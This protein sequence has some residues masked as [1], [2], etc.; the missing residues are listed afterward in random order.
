[1]KKDSNHL[2][3]YLKCFSLLRVERD[4]IEPRS[5]VLAIMLKISLVGARAEGNRFI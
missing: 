4:T 3:Y 1:M 5:C 2:A